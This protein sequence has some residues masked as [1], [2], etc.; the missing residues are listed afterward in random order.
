MSHPRPPADPDRSALPDLHLGVGLDN[1]YWAAEA[2]G[3]EL[4]GQCGWSSLAL[5][6][7]DFR[8]AAV[9][10]TAPVTSK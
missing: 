4:D 7:T 6:P 3:P 9:V 8:K 2:I 5:K 1:G 10:V